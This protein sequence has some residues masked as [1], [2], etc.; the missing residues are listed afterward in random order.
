MQEG[1][2]FHFE[3][4]KNGW[5]DLVKGLPAKTYEKGEILYL[6]GQQDS[7]F[8]YL[9][10]G[11]VKIFLTSE[12]GMEKTLMQLSPD[13]LFGEAAFLD[14]LPRMSSAKVTE[15][16]EVISIGRAELVARF[17]ES[18]NLALQ[19]LQF[20]AKT[21]RML[22]SQV[23]T[24]SFLPAETRVSQQLLA[25]PQKN[26]C[27]ACTQQDLAELT[28]SSRVTV[29]RVIRNFSEKGWI[30]CSYRSICILDQ[31]ALEALL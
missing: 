3:T 22:S 28:G 12:K 30:H 21:V 17:Q 18:P 16:A 13:S 23:D 29:S 31:K 2:D 19:M 24:I 26:G 20:L 7:Y 1:M 9:K 15:D 6:Q 4:P 10:S 5:S 25:L 14:G 11:K 8:Y 27:V